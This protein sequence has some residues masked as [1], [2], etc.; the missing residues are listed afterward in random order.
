MSSFFFGIS[1]HQ[2]LELSNP[3]VASLY[4]THKPRLPSYGSNNKSQ[5]VEECRGFEQ[6]KLFSQFSL[7]FHSLHNFIA[8]IFDCDNKKNITLKS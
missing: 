1:R 8:T 2:Q 6:K 7:D 3:N 4:Q 5:S